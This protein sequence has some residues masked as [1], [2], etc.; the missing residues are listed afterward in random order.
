MDRIGLNLFPDHWTGKE[1][2]DHWRLGL[3]PKPP[4]KQRGM[5][6]VRELL[7]LVW[8]GTV[9]VEAETSEGVYELLAAEDVRHFHGGESWVGDAD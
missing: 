7:A 6:A 2:L 3:H 9:T 8:D 4:T 5:A 1:Y